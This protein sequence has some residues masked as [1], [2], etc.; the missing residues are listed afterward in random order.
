MLKF[1]CNVLVLLFLLACSDNSEE[2]SKLQK[3]VDDLQMKVNDSHKPGLGDFMSSIQIHH[4]KLWFAGINA[5][6]KLAEFEIEEIV[7]SFEDMSKYQASKEEVKVIPVIYPPL[8]SLK[9]SIEKKNIKLFKERF[10]V[11]TETCNSWHK[12][13]KYEFNRVQ[14]PDSPPFSNQIF[15]EQ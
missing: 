12:A 15:T 5:N 3:Q 11:L 4:A 13:V 1:C 9:K 7:E 14:I 10:A 8:G 6:W 2:I